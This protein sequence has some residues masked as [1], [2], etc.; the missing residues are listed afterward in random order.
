MEWAEQGTLKDA[1]GTLDWPTVDASPADLDGLAAAH[2]TGLVHRDIKP[3]NILLTA[4]G[5]KL[6]DFGIACGSERD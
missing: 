1:L 2:A 5:Q 3:D 6:T 4:N